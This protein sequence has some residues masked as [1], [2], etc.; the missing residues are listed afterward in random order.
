MPGAHIISRDWDDVDHSKSLERFRHLF[1]RSTTLNSAE[2]DIIISSDFYR[3]VQEEFR[4]N[5]E[6]A[7]ARQM[8]LFQCYWRL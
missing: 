2:R 6:F 5:V 3:Y 4:K 1:R 8:V 7:K